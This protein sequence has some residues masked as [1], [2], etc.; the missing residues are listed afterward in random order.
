M[1]LGLDGNP[2]DG[3]NPELR[4][5]Y[6]AATAFGRALRQADAASRLNEMEG[7]EAAIAVQERINAEITDRIARMTAEHQLSMRYLI[8]FGVSA[9]ERFAFQ[10]LLQE[11]T[12]HGGLTLQEAANLV[13]ARKIAEDHSGNAPAAGGLS[14]SFAAA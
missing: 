8:Q 3:T 13:H 14:S 10:V 9:D 6:G 12:Q 11:I 1:P 5:R 7:A 2:Y 4:G